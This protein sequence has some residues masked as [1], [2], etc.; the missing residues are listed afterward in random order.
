MLQP[1]NDS[2]RKSSGT[3]STTKSEFNNKNNNNNQLTLPSISLPK[4]GGAIRGMGEKF[5]ANPVTGTASVSIPIFT[6]PGRSSFGPSLSLSYDSGSGN[7]PFGFGWNLS[8]PSVSRKT[9]KGLPTYEDANES[10]TFILSGAEDLVPVLVEVGGKWQR[11]EP[12]IRNVNGADYSI[13]L[14]RPRIEG[15]FARVERWTDLGSGQIH[16]RSISRENI[17]TLYGKTE[18]SRI[19]DPDDPLHIFS[20]LIC[21]S[22]DDKGN[23]IIYEYVKE[24]STKVDL[25]AVHEKNRSQKSHSANRYLKRIKYGNLPSRLVQSNLS[26]MNWMFEVVFDYGEHDQNKPTPNDSGEWLCRHDPFSSFRAGFDVRTYRLCQRVLMF[27]HFPNEEGVGNNCLV[28]STDFVYRNIR[29]RPDDLKKGHP[30]ASFI[31]SITQSGYKRL[32]NDSGSGSYLKK[33]M[34]PVEFEYSQAIIDEEIR[35][36]D[37]E[38]L[39]N[40][41]YGIDG[42][43]YQWVDLDGEGVSGVLTEQGD[44]WFY[45]PNLGGGRFGP[46]ERVAFK[47]SIGSRDLNGKEHKLLDLAGDGQLDLVELSGAT[48]GFYERNQDQN[49]E[50]FV[51][52]ESLPNVNWSDPNLRFVDLTG[53]GH[54]DI[55]VTE[56][57]ALT[58]YPSLAERGFGSASSTTAATNDLMLRSQDE[59]EH[60]PRLIFSDSTQSIYLADMSGDGLTDLVRI[61][62]GEVCYWPNLG[63]GRFGSKVTMDNSP[64]FDAPDMFDQSRIRLA[65]IDGSGVTDI[66]YIGHDDGVRLYFN[67]S[68]NSWAEP[69][70]LNHFPHIDNISSVAALDLLGNGT[71]CLVWSSPLI[72]DTHGPMRYVDLMGGGGGQKEREEEELMEKR[73]R[74]GAGKPH[75]LIS[76]KNN[77]GAE[78]Q[79]EYA[80]STIFYLA[81]KAAGKPWVTKL[82]FPV[83]VV[84]RVKT[85]DYIS[86][87][88]FVNHYTYHH[89]YFDGIEREF[90][91][92]GMVE[93]CD[94]EEF[95]TFSRDGE[96]LLLFSGVENIDESS[97]VPPVLTK[98]WFHTGIYLGRDHVSNFF[99]GQLDGHDKGEYYREPAWEND[100][101]EAEKHVLDD[102]LLPPGTLMTVEEER[103]ACRALKGSMLRQEVYALDGTDKAQDPYIVTE[104]NFSIRMLQPL[105]NNGNNNNN[106]HAVF[107]AHSNEA[108]SYHYERNRDDPRSSHMMTLEVDDFGNILKQA[109]IG[110]GRRRPDPNPLLLD[111]DR[112]KQTRQLITYTENRFTNAIDSADDYRT[113]L[114]CE[115]CTYELTG[116]TMTGSMGRFLPSDFVQP[117][118]DNPGHLVHIFDSE[119]NYEE[120]PTDGR[121]R[122]LIEQVRTLYRKNDLTDFRSLG[123]LESLGLQAESYK[124][125]FTPGL[126]AQVFRRDGQPLLPDDPSDPNNVNNVL[127][128]QGGDQCGYVSSQQLKA[129]GKFPDTDP[130]NHWWIHTGQLF[131]SPNAGDSEAEE[132]DY[133]N[134]HFFLPHRYRDPFHTDAV[135]TESF[136]TFDAYDLLTLE[137]RDA[138]SNRVTVGERLHDGIHPGNDY[139]VLQPRL[140]TDPNG[141]RVEVKFDTLGM[142]AGTAVKGKDNTVGDNLNDGFETD[143]SQDEINEFFDASDPHVPALTFLKEATTRVIYDL[144]SFHRT[145]EEHPENPKQWLPVYAATMTRETHVRDPLLPPPPS[146]ADDDLK[147]QIS[148]SY[149]DGF[150]REIQKKI[151]AE[152]GPLVEGGPVV[153]PRW[154]GSG[155]TIFN[156]IGKPVQQY[157]PFF[158]D[159][160]KFKFGEKVGVS[161]ILFYDP[162]GRVVVTLHPNHTYE[163]VVFDP[164]QQVTYDVN[165]TVAAHGMQTG[166]PRTDADIH[167]YVAKYFAA[168]GDDP[169]PWQTWLEQRQDGDMGTE[170]QIAAEKAS[171]HAD[172]PATTYFDTLGRPF[173]TLAHN[174]FKGHGRSG[175]TATI[176]VD[177]LYVT[178]VELDIE[179]N[180][181]E[182]RDAIVQKGDA[183][184]RI[185][186]RYDYDMLSN[187][188]HQL[189]METNARWMLNDV[190]G[191]S[192]RAWD[193]RDHIFRIEYDPLRRVLRSFVTGADPANTNKELL[194]ER[195]VYGESLSNPEVH[196]LRGKVVEVFDQTGKVITND[197]DFKGNLLRSQRQLA[198]SVELTPAYKT[199]VDWSASIQLETDTT[200][201]S[202]TRYDALNR[203]IQ[204]IAPH[205]DQ[206]GAKLNVIQPVY[207]QANFLEQ[208]HVWL[209]H[210]TEPEGL[211]NPGTVPPSPVGVDNI[212]YDA[213]GQ[214]K[215][216][217]YKNGTIT[218]YD[219]DEQT[220]RLIHLLTLRNAD[221]FPEDCQQ[222]PPDGWPGCQIQNL[223][224]TYD[225]VGNITKIRDDAQQRIFFRNMRVEPSAEYTYDAIYRLIEATGREHLG[226]VHGS[227]PTPHSYNDASRVNRRHPN[228]RDAMGPY[229]EH[230]V[231]DGVGNILEMHHYGTNLSSPSWTRS[232]EYE[233]TS[234]TEDGSTNGTLRKTSNRLSS[235]TVEGNNPL[236]ETYA[237]DNHGNMTKMPQLQMMQW[238]FKDQLF[239]TRRQKVNDED[240]DGN[241]RHGERTYYTYDSTGQRVRKITELPS[242][243]LKDE[244][245]YLGQFEIYRRQLGAGLVRETLH[246]MHDKQRI[247]LVETRND[248]DDDTPKQLIR[249]QLSNHLCSAILELD[250]DAHIISYEEYFP[251]G[252]T[253]YQAVGGQTEMPKRYRY[254]GKERDEETGLY[255]HG[256]RYYAPWLAIWTSCDPAALKSQ[257]DVV[258]S[259]YAAFALNP[260]L[261]VDPDGAAPKEPTM[262]PTTWERFKE[263]VRQFTFRIGIII[264]DNPDTPTPPGLE[265]ASDLKAT[266]AANEAEDELRR[267]KREKDKNLPRSAPPPPDDPDATPHRSGGEGG[268]GK[269]HTEGVKDL[270]G[271]GPTPHVNSLDPSDALKLSKTESMALKAGTIIEGFIPDPTDAFALWLFLGKTIAE[272]KKEVREKNYTRGFAQGLAASVFAYEFSE[273]KDELL[274]QNRTPLAGEISAGWEGVGQRA[275][276]QGVIAGFRL[277]EK[278]S[279]KLRE[280]LRNDTIE[281]MKTNGV[282][283]NGIFDRNFVKDAGEVLIPTVIEYFA[284][285]EELHKAEQMRAHGKELQK[286][287]DAGRKVIF[288]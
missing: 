82:P 211:L 270:P 251:Y 44:A 126:L 162:V 50:N 14:Y 192:I 265:P 58:W 155:W 169:I 141:N 163:K 269:L 103:E 288:Y 43:R 201:T 239:M 99:A 52:F 150:G 132:L 161:P 107:F 42:M 24:D 25:S 274:I 62:N 237:Y 178:R 181:R 249:Y 159:T 170:E 149:S 241:E 262:P 88:F 168:L 240:D 208:M 272:G 110:Y 64:W 73:R 195:L 156:N 130:D 97:N 236:L 20:W 139:R 55:L 142:V 231:Y 105:G 30:I 23:A 189:S 138:V 252:S 108:I 95:G 243:K 76:I 4:G 117:D 226:Q 255:Y 275:F 277:G 74:G 38:S 16:W 209:E 254:T 250:H 281:A 29:N 266:N 127:G 279:I 11:Q 17:T 184:G 257:I 78:T 19:S 115:S 167:G 191:K 49:W 164:W 194:T 122:R 56:N 124:L 219:Y 200:Y 273:A 218:L 230:Y 63:Y 264:S 234:L 87:N 75:L 258:L 120:Q 133:A 223:H 225:P 104:Q 6:S 157:E 232:Y 153:S 180:Q 15:L 112:E 196:N 256:A 102:T 9:D 18:N 83:H 41:P 36:I 280:R 197:Y 89:G 129:D 216:I 278:L 125:A 98:T 244:R 174:R 284:K 123:E 57:E 151:Q 8:L 147:I 177:E 40:L 128:G 171:A 263:K 222:P 259:S 121:Q 173:L 47:P 217:D 229:T 212:D 46:I 53:D 152:S 90:R 242:G 188:I 65:D 61:R 238:D 68:G 3:P 119:I 2:I 39:Q 1:M 268:G 48:P 146:P 80:S 186:M 285:K 199:T 101:Q 247:A 13:M 100:D 175:T 69:V 148:F 109:A 79:V 183:R 198:K 67:E 134:Q 224:Y 235:T 287:A 193:S 72:G 51:P 271:G 71:A 26:Q 143:L 81:D 253:S 282:S 179:G 96:E 111:T 33:S 34:P 165:D 66:I 248:V 203:P 207:N 228:E 190:T 93:Q 145:Q 114:P 22:Y 144:H 70:L 261:Y 106:R 221:T 172:T 7:G 204:L 85:F 283:W 137:S 37:S 10:D 113:P 227:A 94:T 35:E 91:G 160:H 86:R 45:K 260:V 27:H 166:D 31:S 210:P 206:P 213:K 136:V 118:P 202:R 187:R 185:V 286:R 215:R 12:V 77:M 176:I 140:V 267:L 21:E 54:A 205:I 158:D 84:E 220:F 59:E 214:R 276:N 32:L 5:G 246:I 245:F 60:G 28:R 233:E 154:V 92:F 116:Y 131:Y 182:V 135:S